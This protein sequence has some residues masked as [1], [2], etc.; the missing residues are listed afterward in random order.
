MTKHICLLLMVLQ[1]LGQERSEIPFLSNICVGESLVAEGMHTAYFSILHTFFSPASVLFTHACFLSLFCFLLSYYE[2]RYRHVM[3]MQLLSWSFLFSLEVIWLIYNTS[4]VGY[5]LILSC[6]FRSLG[7]LLSIMCTHSH[8]FEF[9]CLCHTISVS[10]LP[11]L[12]HY[13]CPSSVCLWLWPHHGFS[14]WV[15][16]LSLI[17]DFFFL[18]LFLR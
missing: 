8:S 11:S 3:A 12:I 4:W 7:Q 15:S 6:F 18:F 5:T 2:I 13:P 14:C 16:K 9:F 17:A 1:P 10:P